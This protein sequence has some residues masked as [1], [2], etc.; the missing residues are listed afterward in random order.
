MTLLGIDWGRARVG[1][2][3]SDELELLA[4]PYETVPASS[5]DAV[6]QE[7]CRLAGQR[8]ARA[9]VLGLPLNMDGSEGDSARTVRAL[10]EKLSAASGKAVV[11]WDER[12]TSWQ[13]DQL[14][15]GSKKGP[16]RAGRQDQ[17]AA[18]L[19][20]QGYLDR[21]KAKSRTAGGPGQPA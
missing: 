10:S 14:L 3:V 2:A 7:L 6:V 20:L 21:E 13:A 18:A 17:A 1:V 19:I 12:L 9:F 5:L 15:R 11:L 8:G 4:H 16:R